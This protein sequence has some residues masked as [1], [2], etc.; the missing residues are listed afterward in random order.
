[1]KKTTEL[2]KQEVEELLDEIDWVKVHSQI[3]FENFGNNICIQTNGKIFSIEQGTSLRD[4]D[5]IIGLIPCI[6]L[7]N[8]DT[9]DYLD[10]WGKWY[11]WKREFETNDG[12]ILDENDAILEAIED[13]EW[14]QYIDEWKKSMMEQWQEDIDAEEY[15]KHMEEASKEYWRNFEL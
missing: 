6:G 2:S 4:D 9:W 1:M 14:Q 11:Q 10:G 3:V 13:G 8:I 7:G 12:R 15:R 5:E